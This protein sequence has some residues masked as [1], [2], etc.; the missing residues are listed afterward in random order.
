MKRRSSQ[1][2]M[3]QACAPWQYSHEDEDEHANGNAVSVSLATKLLQLGDQS[4]AR[5][6]DALFLDLVE[7][8]QQLLL[9][10]GMVFWQVTELGKA[11]L[12]SSARLRASEP[13]VL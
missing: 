11:S 4:F 3:S 9:N 12:C 5:L 2:L 8:M 10:I 1:T 7:D 13:S 6:H